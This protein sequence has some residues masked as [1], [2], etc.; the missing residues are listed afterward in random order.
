MLVILLSALLG[1]WIQTVS[2]SEDS[3]SAGFNFAAIL[4]LV[5]GTQYGRVW[6]TRMA[7]VLLLGFL[8]IARSHKQEEP[9][10]MAALFGEALLSAALLVTL[11]LSGH[12]S[13]G[14]GR[15]FVLQVFFD[16]IHLLAAGL[17]LGGLLPL[18]VLLNRCHR[19]PGAGAY[20]SAR[21]AMGRFSMLALVSVA[22]LIGSGAYNAWILVG[23]FAPLFGTAYGKLLLLKLALLLPLLALGALNLLRLKPRIV[24]ASSTRAEETDGGFEIAFTQHNL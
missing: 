3:S 12:A 2:V 14:D 9:L 20:A 22:L 11:A 19:N 6:L 23:G 15:A 13:A 8:L 1:L 5:A 10:S 24:I 17:W 4:S 7:I 18:V 16:A 21:I